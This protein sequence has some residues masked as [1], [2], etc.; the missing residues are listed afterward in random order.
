MGRRRKHD[1]HL[2]QRVYSDRQRWHQSMFTW[3]AKI[4]EVQGRPAP[5]VDK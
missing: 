2:P 4:L 5:K 3:L 1:K